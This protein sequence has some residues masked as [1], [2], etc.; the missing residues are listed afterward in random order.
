MRHAFIILALASLIILHIS[1]ARQSPAVRSLQE[2]GRTAGEVNDA[3]LALKNIHASMQGNR[4]TVAGRI[5]NVWEGTAK[6]APCTFILRDNSAALEIVHW[7]KSPLPVETGDAVEC[8]GT[9]GLY[10]GRLQLR[11]WSTKD[12]QVLSP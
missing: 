12:M 2:Q 1:T 8:T 4:I 10:R 6:R 7:L 5:S 9:V 3:A 11:L